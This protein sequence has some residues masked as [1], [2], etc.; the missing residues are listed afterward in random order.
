LLLHILQYIYRTE[1]IFYPG[2]K[3]KMNRFLP[4]IPKF[5]VI[6]EYLENIGVKL[7]CY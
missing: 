4:I 1:A 3:H 6:E 2:T 7:K 5:T